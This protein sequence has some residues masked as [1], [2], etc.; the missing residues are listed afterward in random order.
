MDEGSLYPDMLSYNIHDSLG[1]PG[2]CN[3][4]AGIRDQF[5]S[6]GVP[7]QPWQVAVFAMLITLLFARPC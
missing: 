2:C 7:F 3:W 6:L 1:N 4:A 5:A